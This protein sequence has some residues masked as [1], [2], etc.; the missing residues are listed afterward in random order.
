[1]GVN[2]LTAGTLTAFFHQY[3]GG[4]IF[5]LD[6]G[7]KSATHCFRLGGGSFPVRLVNIRFSKRIWLANNI[8]LLIGLALLARCLPFSRPMRSILSRNPWL[9]RVAE[10]D[11]VASLAGG[12][13]FSDIYGLGRFWYVC[14]PQILAL[15]L[16]KKLVLLPQTIGPFK[17]PLVKLLARLVMSKAALVYSRDREGMKEA[18]RILGLA[19]DSGKV[20]FCYD[21]GFALQP[22]RPDTIDLAGLPDRLERKCPVVGVNVS[23][24]LFM[25]GYTQNNMFGLRVDYRQLVRDVIGHFVE[26]K[27]AAVL[28]VPHV[29]GTKQ[30]DESDSAACELV[31][32]ELKRKH[33]DR[34]FVVRGNYREGEIKYIIG[35]CDFFVG[36]RM[37]ACIAALS[38]GIPAVGI[39]YS[40]KFHGVFQT[41]G[42]ESYVADPRELSGSE[43][44]AV[45][46]RAYDRRAVIRGQLLETMAR[47]KETVLGLFPEIVKAV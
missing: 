7:K 1:M 25:G 23:G 37:H 9:E 40:R 31:Y 44:L 16:E 6:Y 19:E 28:L 27:G 41:I 46:D 17:H 32:A 36:S 15:L 26:Q 14:L 5:L 39:A 24:L 33:P 38:Q 22:V 29:F 3:P 43:I 21:V 20:R 30:L 11:L 13:S 34:I 47:V 12:D 18:R 10:A 45:I 35:L 2:A 42:A 8:A 4:E